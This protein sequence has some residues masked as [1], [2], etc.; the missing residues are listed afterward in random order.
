MDPERGCWPSKT[1]PEAGKEEEEG[2]R[3]EVP[4][5]PVHVEHGRV[6]R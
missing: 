2:P 3:Q 5:L 1:L 4:G 6:K